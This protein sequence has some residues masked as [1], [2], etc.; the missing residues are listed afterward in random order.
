MPYVQTIS[1]S[2]ESNIRSTNPTRQTLVEQLKVRTLIQKTAISCFLQKTRA[3]IHKASKT[4]NKPSLTHLLRPNDVQTS[5]FA[6]Y[7]VAV[8]YSYEIV[9]GKTGNVKK[10][11]QAVGG[12]SRFHACDFFLL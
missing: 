3:K 11:S 1:S 9:M 2:I 12:S 8:K 7:P 6:H 5:A 10:K 4:K